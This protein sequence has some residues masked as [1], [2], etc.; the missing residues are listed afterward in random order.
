MLSFSHEMSWMR[1]GRIE[2]ILEGF[3][4]FLSQNISVPKTM[5][6]YQLSS[7]YCCSVY[8]MSPDRSNISDYSECFLL[9]QRTK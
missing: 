1:S 2:S 7:F 3:L 4:L 9:S 5:I 8:I 6:S